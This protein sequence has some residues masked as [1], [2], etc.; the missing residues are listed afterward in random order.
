MSPVRVPM[1]RPEAGVK[2]I[3]VST[4]RPP[5]TAARLDPAP[6]CASTTRPRAAAAPAT[7]SSS[8]IRKAYDS[9]WNP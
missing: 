7:R 3:V 2:P 8:P 6:R 1:T 9:P 5:W 4:G